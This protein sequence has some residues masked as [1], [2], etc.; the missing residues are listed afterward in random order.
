MG[1]RRGGRQ[2]VDEKGA[3][4]MEE[5]ERR[6]EKRREKGQQDCQTQII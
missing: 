5:E 1:N 4:V 6:G 2:G 3:K